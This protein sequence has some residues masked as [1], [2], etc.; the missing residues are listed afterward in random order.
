MSFKPPSSASE[1]AYFRRPDPEKDDPGEIAEG[2]Y[3]GVIRWKCARPRSHLP[4]PKAR[5]GIRF[6][7]HIEG[8]SPTVFAHACKMA[9][10]GIVSTRKDWI[11]RSGRSPDWLKKKNA[12]APAV[13]RQAEEDWGR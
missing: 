13:K 11:Y 4:W 10:E 3:Y 2:T 7:E 6:N 12:N 8:D 1:R 9:L 5:L